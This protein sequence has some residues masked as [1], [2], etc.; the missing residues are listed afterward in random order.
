MNLSVDLGKRIPRVYTGGDFDLMKYI[1]L[2]NTS[3]DKGNTDK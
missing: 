2:V 1:V 3:D